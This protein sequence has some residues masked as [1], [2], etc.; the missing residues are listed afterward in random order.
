MAAERQMDLQKVIQKVIQS[1]YNPYLM[2]ELQA[3]GW[4]PFFEEA[5][6]QYRMQGFT[7]G[8]VAS[9]HKNIYRVHVA[10]GELLARVAGK[11]LHRAETSGDFPAVGDWV[12]I[13]EH[14]DQKSASI[15]GVLPRKS[16]F[17]R[18]AAGENVREQIAA[19]NVDTIFLIQGLDH[20]FNLR[21]T[22]RY[23]VMGWES[24]ARPVL[25]LS[26]SD[27]CHDIEQK[28]QDVTSIAPGVR[29]HAIS[30]VK[31]QGV[32][33]LYP[34]IYDGQTIAFLGS[35]GAGKSTLINRLLGQERQKVR[36]VREKDGKGRHTTTYREL[37]LLPQGGCLIDT[38]GMRELQLWSS[39]DG[40][41]NA[42]S[43]I[44]TLSANCRYDDCRHDSEPECAVK[45]AVEEGRLDMARLD[46]YR[47]LEK[48]V[49]YLNSRE[50]ISLSLERKAKWRSIHR[51][52]RKTVTHKRT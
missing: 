12:V 26:K 18:K 40:F 37:I 35:S 36:E 47:K 23:L 10:G 21:R 29:V 25:V 22:E 27:L 15:L 6:F 24:G 44:S 16:K 42:F 41:Q 2:N 20:D 49:E 52:I 51:N 46:S 7:A 17:S 4:S 11:L 9:E 32:E 38:P 13:T 8:R 3:L 50:D 5:F 19:A 31:N 39:G 43:D 33:E 45:K 28:L 1:E 14:K 34:Y 48:E 30:S